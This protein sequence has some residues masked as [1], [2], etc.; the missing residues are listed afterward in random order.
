MAMELR[1]SGALPI[2]DLRLA[3]GDPPS[4][5][6]VS[7]PLEY[8]ANPDICAERFRERE[9]VGATGA[10]EDPVFDCVEVASNGLDLGVWQVANNRITQVALFGV[11]VLRDETGITRDHPQRLLP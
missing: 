10:R 8:R 6:R 5:P 1:A 7:S 11:Q 2:T 3:S 9:V 4:Q